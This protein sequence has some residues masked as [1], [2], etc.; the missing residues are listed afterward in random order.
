MSF[1]YSMSPSTPPRETNHNSPLHSAIDILDT[2][3]D[4]YHER[5]IWVTRAKTDSSVISSDN[6]S[7]KQAGGDTQRPR[8]T[9]G[10]KRT[11][12]F[13][14]PKSG[15]A[16][17]SESSSRLDEGKEIILELYDKLMETRLESCRR[18]HN[19]LEQQQEYR[20]RQTVHNT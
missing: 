14:S 4:F 9:S 5:R 2:L 15:P 8:T 13:V 10:W 7:D 19:L 6:I 3:L 18:I 17:R 1:T 11:E 16:L 12:H 20:Y